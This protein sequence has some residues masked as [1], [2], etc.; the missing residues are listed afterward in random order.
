MDEEEELGPVGLGL[1]AALDL[2]GDR[3]ED[4]PDLSPAADFDAVR[5]GG[6]HAGER[7]GAGVVFGCAVEHV[8]PCT[9]ANRVGGGG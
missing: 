9:L 5:Q 1:L 7:A 3:R 8:E 4:L 6:G 2:G